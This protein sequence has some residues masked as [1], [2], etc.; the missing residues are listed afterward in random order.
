MK[1]KFKLL[2]KRA[3]APSVPRLGDAGIDFVAID[4]EKHEN[5]IEYYT[6]IAVEIPE[7]YVGLL[8]P[9]SSISKTNQTL[10]NS[11]GVVDSSYRGEVRVRM[12]Q[13]SSLSPKL[14]NVGDKVCQLVI[15]PYTHVTELVEGEL[16]ETERGEGGFGSTGK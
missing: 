1:L 3:K 5:Y 12:R 10:A 13:D 11:V 6:G 16:T 2:D 15:M 4:L 7:G 8:F 9:R 14:Y